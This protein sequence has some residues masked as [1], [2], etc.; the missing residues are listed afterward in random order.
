MPAAHWARPWQSKRPTCQENPFHADALCGL[1]SV[2]GELGDLDGAITAFRRALQVQPRH[3]LTHFYLGAA[4]G[5]K[6]DVDGALLEFQ[7]VVEC[8][9]NCR[10]AE[11]AR[12]NLQAVAR[13][14][15]EEVGG[16]HAQVV[17]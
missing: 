3:A 12:A 1:G 17:P 10:A 15:G 5:R 14:D 11:L 9:P 13:A 4:L 6:G 16:G 2:M 8:D 7:A